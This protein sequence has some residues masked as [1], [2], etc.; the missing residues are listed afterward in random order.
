M[1]TKRQQLDTTLAALRSERDSSVMAHWRELNQ[2]LLPYTGRFLSSDRNNIRKRNEKVVNETATFSVQTAQRGMMH[3]IT[4]PSRPWLQLAT[5]WPEMNDEP[6]V[7]QWL[8]T[9]GT[10][11]L[12]VFR[13]SN[14]YTELPKIYTDLVVYGT[15]ACVVNR[16]P[17]TVIRMESF[18]IGSYMLSTDGT[19]R[20]DT[21]AREWQMTR[22]QVISKFGYE[23]CSRDIQSSWDSGI[24]LEEGVEICHILQPNPDWNPRSPLTMHKKFRSIYWEKAAQDDKFLQESGYDTF[25]ILT[26]RWD[27]QEADAYGVSPA[28]HVL[29]TLKGLQTLEKQSLQ[30]LAKV[31]NPPLNVPVGLKGQTVTQLAGGINYY[32]GLDQGEIK[33]AFQVGQAPLMD[34][35]AKIQNYELRLRKALFEDVFLMVTNGRPDTTAEEIRARIEEKI[36]TLGPIMLR[37]NDELLD[38]MVEVTF[39]IMA[40]HGGLIPPAPE[41]L[42]DSPLQIEYISEMAKAMKLA[43][44]SGIERTIGFIGNFAQLKPSILDKINEDEVADIYSELSGAPIQIINDAAAVKKIRQVRQDKLAQ[45]EQIQKAGAAAEISK[46]M[47]EADPES[48]LLGAMSGQGVNVA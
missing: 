46:T 14:V 13:K 30:L 43:G 24:G 10:R 27:V 45:A 22:R 9:V 17:K 33:P 18:P 29:G 7:R 28:M 48:G 21:C 5:P 26:P 31:I 15:S 42:Q 38:Q 16:D 12:D 25:R 47:S 36:Q 4:N 40:S 3:A 34:V 20:V 2:Y 37:L 6:D 41:V 44:V 32:S 1:E 19:G 39:E 11:I 35:E 8:D 23:A